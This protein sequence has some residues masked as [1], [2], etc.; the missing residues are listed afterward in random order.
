[1]M[2]SD[3]VLVNMETVESPCVRN[4]CLDRDDICMGCYRSMDEITGWNAASL[5]E[6]NEILVRVLKRKESRV[7]G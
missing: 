4:C 6:K 1:M 5:E 7:K 3:G 2:N